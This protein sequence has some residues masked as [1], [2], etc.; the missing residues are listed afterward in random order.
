MADFTYVFI[1]GAGGSARIWAE[2]LAAFPNSIAVTL[3][4]HDPSDLATVT[5]SSIE[6]HA[7]HLHEL[8]RELGDV[9]LVGHSMGGAIAQMYALIFP[10]KVRGLVLIGTG[11][12]MRVSPKILDGLLTDYP[13]TVRFIVN[14]GFPPDAPESL[15]QPLIEDMEALPP[16]VTHAAF[17]ACN[18]FD[19]TQNLS[20]LPPMPVLVITGTADLLTPPKLGQFLADN[21]PGARFEQIEG[22]GHFV[23]VEKPAELN[24]LLQE[25]EA[26]A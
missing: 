16:E 18:Q 7:H 23:Q 19:V 4:G 6:G 21:I 20:Q 24:G 26:N 15:K 9:V 5:V 10:E 2:Q 25:F 13:A 12:K 14:T 22:V 3:V 8:L 1:H 17:N 11:A